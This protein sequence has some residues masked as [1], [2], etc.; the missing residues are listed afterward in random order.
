MAKKGKKETKQAKYLKRVGWSGRE[1][2]LSHLYTKKTKEAKELREAL[3]TVA[4]E[5]GRQGGHARAK[6]LSKEALAA[7]GKKGAATRWGKPKKGGK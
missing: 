6:N 2:Y 1:Q 7:I 4:R 5:L 3:R